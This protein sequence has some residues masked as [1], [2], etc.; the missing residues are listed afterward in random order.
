MYGCLLYDTALALSKRNGMANGK[1][2]VCLHTEGHFFW[3]AVMYGYLIYDTAFTL[4]FY[5]AVGSPAFLAH[6][7]L[8]L[9]ACAFGL[10]HNRCF[11]V[12]IVRFD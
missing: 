7:A 5:S 1:L 2:H 9:A 10:Y 11:I 4:V 12:L 3:G 6:H 8:G